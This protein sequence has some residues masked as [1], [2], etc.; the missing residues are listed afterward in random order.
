MG[1]HGS[2]PRAGR[3]FLGTIILFEKERNYQEQSHPKKQSHSEKNE[4]IERVLKTFGK[5]IKRTNL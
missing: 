4:H 1:G 5:I 2:V 3:H